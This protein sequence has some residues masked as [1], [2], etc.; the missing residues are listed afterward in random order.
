MLWSDVFISYF[1]KKLAVIDIKSPEILPITSGLPHS[2][3]RSPTCR[4]LVL[5]SFHPA[6]VHLFPSRTTSLQSPLSFLPCQLISQLTVCQLFPSLNPMTRSLHPHL[7]WRPS[8]NTNPNPL[9]S[10]GVFTQNYRTYFSFW[11]K[12]PTTLKRR[13]G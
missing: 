3:T 1:S 6:S 13:C 5:F 9:A 7:R 10:E 11:V 2:S 12:V 8:A 4:A